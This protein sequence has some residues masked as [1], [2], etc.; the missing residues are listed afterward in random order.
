MISHSDPSEEFI[1]S[2][3]TILGPGSVLDHVP[4]HSNE[5]WNELTDT[6]AKQEARS[7]FYL[8]RPQLDF[9]AL[10]P[11]LPHLWML[12]DKTHGLPTYTEGGLM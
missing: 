10:L 3:I 2:L 4:G 9:Q 1:I 12:F 11:K 6:L 5:P 8:P 7:S